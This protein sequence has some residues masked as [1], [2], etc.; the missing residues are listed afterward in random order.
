[1]F[2]ICKDAA[3][4]IEPNH[5]QT[6]FLITLLLVTNLTYAEKMA[7]FLSENDEDVQI[8]PMYG[9]TRSRPLEKI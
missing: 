2:I 4:N 8:E 1:M 3:K 7:L 5:F 6:Y 9:P